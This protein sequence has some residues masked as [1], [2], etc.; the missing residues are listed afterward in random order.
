MNLNALI[1]KVNH[2]NFVKSK[3]S[4]KADDM[5]KYFKDNGIEDEFYF[6]RIEMDKQKGEIR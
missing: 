2:Y 4:H 5:V 1:V 3:C 6:N